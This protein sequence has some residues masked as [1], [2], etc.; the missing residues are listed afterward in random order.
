VAAVASSIQEGGGGGA[1]AVS[2]IL[3]SREQKDAAA[4]ATSVPVHIRV[5]AV[6]SLTSCSADRSL[7]EDRS[8]PLRGR[9]D[10]TATSQPA[11]QLQA[12]STV[13]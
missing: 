7:F 3:I 8:N 9:R 4:A 6:T 1:G 10:G 13:T 12:D 5:L 2:P 11:G